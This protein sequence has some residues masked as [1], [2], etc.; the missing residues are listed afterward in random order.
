[1][2]EQL[3][4]AIVIVLVAMPISDAFPDDLRFE[5]GVKGGPYW[6]ALRGDPVSVWLGGDD[7]QLAGTIANYQTAFSGGAFVTMFFNDI[8]GVQAELMYAPKGGEGTAA[9]Q[10]VFYPENDNPRPAFFNGTVSADLDYV[11]IPVMAVLELEASESGKLRVRG[12][13]GFTLGFNVHA[14]SRLEGTA[15]IRMQDTSKRR[16]SVDQTEDIGSRVKGQ[17]FGL[18]FGGAVY[19]DIGKMDFLV[20]SRWERG[21][22]T[23]DNT[24]LYRDVRTSNVSL[25]FGLSYPFGG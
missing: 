14:Q 22:T 21:L 18:I 15:E 1:M 4:A 13:A 9:G 8:F 24:T 25:M 19:Y 23:I 11:E 3:I 10:I 16:Y 17:E 12:L 5:A 2:R 20:E 6:A 7:G